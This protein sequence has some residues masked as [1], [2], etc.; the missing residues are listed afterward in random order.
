[1]EDE[2]KS[3]LK[4]KRVFKPSEEFI[5]NAH[6]KSLQE[7]RKI[8]EHSVKNP[9]K[10]WAEKALQLHWFKKWKKVL[11]KNDDFYKWFEGGKINVC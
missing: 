10:F 2:F 4:E 9:E 3:L 8:Y 7:Y 5:K 11:T 1:M 6:I